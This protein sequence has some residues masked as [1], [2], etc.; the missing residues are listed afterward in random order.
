MFAGDAPEWLAA[1]PEPVQLAI[2]LDAERGRSKLITP[3]GGTVTATGANGTRYSLRIP[4]GALLSDELITLIPVAQVGGLP[5]TGDAFQTVQLEPS[6]LQLLEA[7][8]L[9]VR[10]RT[11]V[12]AAEQVAFG[13]FGM[14]ADAHLTPIL[15][16]ERGRIEIPVLHFSGYGYGRAAP[17]D[18]G[19]IALQKAANHEARLSAHV[20][21]I[22]EAERARQL[23][24][25]PD[26]A[27]T[28]PA[29]NTA[30]SDAFIEYYDAVLE[31]LM[32]IAET[33]ERMANCAI[34]RYTA[35]ERQIQL[36]GGT[37]DDLR[38]ARELAPPGSD[39]QT[40]ALQQRRNQAKASFN[41]ILENAREKLID[42]AIERCRNEQDFTVVR[43]VLSIKR[44]AALLG[45]GDESA[46]FMEEMQ[47]VWDCL[48]FEVEFRSVI[49][50]KMPTGGTYHHV[51][52]KVVHTAFAAEP[53]TAPL[54]YVAYRA[55]GNPARDLMGDGVDAPGWFGLL[56]DAEATRSAAGTRAGTAQVFS[57]SWNLNPKKATGTNCVGEDEETTVEISDTLTVVIAPG[58]PIELMRLT[59]LRQGEKPTIVRGIQE[60]FNDKLGLAAP[61][62]ESARI[63]GP[64]VSEETHWA[65]EWTRRHGAQAVRIEGVE[66]RD[67]AG[68]AYKVRL[69]RVAKG[70]WRAE[71]KTDD[72]PMSGFA[73][74]EDSYI[75][76]RHTPK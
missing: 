32:R 49:E 22:L 70:V 41:R 26:A 30:V 8:T 42:R 73:T 54:E 37:G 65:K 24:L 10:S 36:L 71:F 39:P 27:D 34:Q 56:S 2:T 57:V 9:T 14:G 4:R 64:I 15:P 23:S 61:E 58:I 13:Y 16:D 6:G 45:M 66:V 5:L 43:T 35:W 3:N 19:R 1:A 55:S 51:T 20:A 48:T 69:A 44:Q 31:P 52:A 68:G 29:V 12:P 28:D 33:D 47:E 46:V 63:G 25:D 38:D 18:P 62:L 11:E 76:V 75:I 21:E 7:A 17:N 74:S 60:G 59:P 72:A 67:E 40:R 50:R 53:Q